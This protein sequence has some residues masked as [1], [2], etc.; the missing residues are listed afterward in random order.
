MPK[1]KEQRFEDMKRFKNV[2]EYTDFEEGKPNP[3]GKWG[4]DIFGNDHEIVLE[5]ACGK[6]EYSTSLAERNPDKNYIGIDIKGNRMWVGATYAQEHDLKNVH[7]FRAFIDHLDKYFG[8]NEVDE[9]WILFPDPYP[10]KERKRL[11][12]PKFL[13]LFRKVLK[14]GGFIHLKTDSDVLYEYTLEVI[15]EEDLNLIQNIPDIYRECPEDPVLT[16]KTYYE[17]KHLEKGKT[18]KYLRFSLN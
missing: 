2:S 5:L 9:I 13:E 3:S 11:T 16:I 7:Y 15:E 1:I 10:K 17:K 4:S 14:P 18:I 6:G 12:A 8:E